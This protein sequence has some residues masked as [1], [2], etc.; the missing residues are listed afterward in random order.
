MSLD[1]HLRVLL[2]EDNPLDARTV[3]RALASSTDVDYDVV[4]VGDLHSALDR[5][6]D[7]V[8][9]CILLD[10]SLPDS[11]GL[12]PVETLTSDSPHCPV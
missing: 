8:F 2:V 1:P 9:D 11:E 6:A 4:H 12:V 10:L 5:V 3:I 7:E